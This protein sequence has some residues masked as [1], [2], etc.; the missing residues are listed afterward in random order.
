LKAIYRKTKQEKFSKEVYLS[1]IVEVA[2]HAGVS[3]ATV[4]R[5]VNKPE[6][7]KPA[8]REKVLN[9]MRAL[10]FYPRGAARVPGT[11]QPLGV[12]VALN[13]VG[14]VYQSPIIESIESELRLA[15]VHMILSSGGIET[16]DQAVVYDFLLRH[17]PERL[18][19]HLDGN[20]NAEL[21]Q[22]AQSGIHTVVLGRNIPELK[23]QCVY[24]DN[25]RGGFMATQYL[26]DCGHQNI[27]HIAGQ[28]TL[29]SH[30]DA[31]DRLSGFY[32]ALE[33][34][35]LFLNK[36]W[37]VE[38]DF[39]ERSGYQAMTT[40]LERDC[41]ATAIFAAND[42]TAAGAIQKLREVGLKVPEDISIIGYDDQ[43]IARYLSPPLTTVRQPFDE[44]GRAAARL[45]LQSLNLY[46]GHVQTRFE[47]RLIER[48]SV[49][50]LTKRT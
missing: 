30:Q 3:I 32:Q 39:T 41:K 44:M 36:D 22:W 20:T 33:E 4:S 8:T 5:V 14:S 7:V 40:L 29:E 49:S 24:L 21:L 17:R 9:A 18:I 10:E 43:I 16:G 42:Q 15:D 37:V 47:P 12:G 2:K 27:A 35:G 1:N 26:I 13:Y 31:S 50:T 38:T 11:D 48:Q 34:N 45:A 28:L 23:G 46:D 25:K 19:L 6:T